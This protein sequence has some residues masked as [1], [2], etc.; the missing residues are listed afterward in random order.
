[1]KHCS[2]VGLISS[3]SLPHHLQ[4]VLSC[5]LLQSVMLTSSFLAFDP[6][7]FRNQD[8]HACRSSCTIWFLLQDF[9][10]F[11]LFL[12]CFLRQETYPSVLFLSCYPF[13]FCFVSVVLRLYGSSCSNCGLSPWVCYS[14]NVDKSCLVW[15]GCFLLSL[16]V[17]SCPR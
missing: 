17:T 7:S 10:Y 12:F 1:M 16:A 15:T 3:F 11:D 14:A 4:F 2:C 8:P 6:D 5:F 9:L 13:S